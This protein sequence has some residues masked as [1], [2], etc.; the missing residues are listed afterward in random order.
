MK[1]GEF[2]EEKR[3]TQHRGA[4]HARGRRGQYGRLDACQLLVPRF[5]DNEPSL[6]RWALPVCLFL[7]EGYLQDIRFRSRRDFA[8]QDT[9]FT[10][11]WSPRTS[12]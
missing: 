10:G 12:G 6:N 5:Q 3:L 4:Q 1:W 8:P 9:K 11:G 7:P 2:K